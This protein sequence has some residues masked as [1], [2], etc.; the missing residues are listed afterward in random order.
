MGAIQCPKVTGGGAVWIHGE[1]S[2]VDAWVEHSLQGG[3]SLTVRLGRLEL[4]AD[5]MR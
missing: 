1:A 4:V 2:F 3:E 5:Y